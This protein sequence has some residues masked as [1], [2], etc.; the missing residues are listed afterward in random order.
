MLNPDFKVSTCLVLNLKAGKA[1]SVGEAL[2]KLFLAIAL[3]F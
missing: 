3:S 1:Y 2:A